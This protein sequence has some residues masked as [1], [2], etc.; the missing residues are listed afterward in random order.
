LKSE[1]QEK[2][3][4]S[5]VAFLARSTVL[6]LAALALAA[7]P[8]RAWAPE[9][10]ATVLGVGAGLG[11]ILIS[12]SYGVLKASLEKSPHAQYTAV[13]LGWFIRFGPTIAALFG[14]LVWTDLPQG[15]TL[16]SVLGFYGLF[17]TYELVVCWRTLPTYAKTAR[18]H[19]DGSVPGTRDRAGVRG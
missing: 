6:A 10:W 3:P 2:E 15:P 13:L 16:A 5:W 9:D 17:L 8:F 7:Y 11:L 12:V 4:P 1:G 14:I 18:S 19:A